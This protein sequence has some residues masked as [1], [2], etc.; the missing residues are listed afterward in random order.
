M[1]AR[2]LISCLVAIVA[3]CSCA[4][5]GKNNPWPA[6]TSPEQIGRRVAERFVAS[7]HPNFGNPR[8][9]GEI[10]YP[11]TCAWYGALTFARLAGD[12]NLSAQLIARFD[13]YSARKE[14]VPRPNR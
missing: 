5:R 13:H 9:P 8:P 2:L 14:T 10:T 4:T 6:G 3:C 12:T 7:P 11:E 1:I